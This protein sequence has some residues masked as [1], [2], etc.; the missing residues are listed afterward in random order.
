MQRKFFIF[1]HTLRYILNIFC[2]KKVWNLTIIYIY[3]CRGN[4]NQ[5]RIFNFY[6]FLHKILQFLIQN[7]I[8]NKMS[9]SF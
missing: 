7:K 8:S 4:Y 9:S 6:S 3:F 2:T 1:F 5:I